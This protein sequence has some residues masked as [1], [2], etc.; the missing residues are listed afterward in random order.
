MSYWER[1]RLLISVPGYR[2]RL[3]FFVFL[4]TTMLLLAHSISDLNFGDI[5]KE[6]AVVF[7]AV[8]FV[9][10]LWDLAGG[11]PTEV[12]LKEMHHHMT[13]L[14]DIVDGNLGIERIWPKRAA[15]QGDLDDGLK[16]WKDRVCE[17][18]I[19][20]IVS[21][22]LFRNWF[23]DDDFIDRF[24]GSLGSKTV[25]ILLIDPDSDIAKLRKKDEYEHRPEFQ[26]EIEA[27]LARIARLRKVIKKA[28][29][30]KLEVRLNRSAYQLAQIIRADNLMLISVYLLGKSGSFATT[31]QIRGPGTELFSKYQEQLEFYW[32]HGVPVSEDEFNS[33]LREREQDL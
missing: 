3:V 1:I 4:G 24:F 7:L 14:S 6:F 15:W 28:D 26:M 5:L 19:V 23:K 22:T 12:Q 27:T 11:D 2:V 17:A 20:D 21:N 10:F 25:Q 9:S 16:V 32:R 33:L 18:K 30:R 31:F 13:V 8:G 29:S